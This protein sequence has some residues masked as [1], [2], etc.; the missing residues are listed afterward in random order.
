MKILKI[1][2]LLIVFLITACGEKIDEIDQK[3]VEL[4]NLK[5]QLTEIKSNIST[6]EMELAQMDTLSEGGISVSIF[7]LE[8]SPFSHYVEQ[9]G[10]VSSKENVLLSSE[11]SGVVQ[12][13][14][15]K[16]GSWVNKGQAILQLDASVLI[17]QVE[18]LKATTELLKT[19]FDR[20][21]NLWDQG[22]GSELQYLQSKNQYVSMQNKLEAAQAQLDKLEISAPI[23]GR[24]DEVFINQGEFATP[25]MPILRVVNSK[26]LQIEVDITERYINKIAK[27]DLVK[28]YISSIDL[29]QEAPISFI[30]QVINPENRTFKVKIDLNNSSGYIKPNAVASLKLN[31]FYV[32]QATVLPSKIIKKDMRGS[33]VFVADGNKAV[34]KYIETGLSYNQNTHVT[35]GLNFGEKIIFNG[36]NEVSNGSKIAIK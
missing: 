22:I 3:R 6:L 5:E 25:G 12:N 21:S 13:I 17:S 33:F 32:D 11:M 4:K 35:S 27:G 16:E 31:D 1:S 9:P 28:I 26:K 7:T 8:P 10:I 23:S 36:F 24:L 20:Q 34:K 15:V 30:G 14:L 29:E 18:D 2:F 19:T